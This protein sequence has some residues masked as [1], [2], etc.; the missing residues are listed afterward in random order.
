MVTS[1]KFIAFKINI[2]IK[3]NLNSF[4]EAIQTLKINIRKCQSRL[5]FFFHLLQ[6]NYI[7][8][9]TY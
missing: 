8:K 6:D 7:K 5:C 4:S 2:T 1:K 3:K 9:K